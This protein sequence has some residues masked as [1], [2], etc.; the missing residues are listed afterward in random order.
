MT[1]GENR[2]GAGGP[3]QFVVGTWAS[4]GVD[5]N[6][7]G[8][9]S[10]YDARDAIPAAARY[11]RASGAPGD[12]RRALFAYNHAGWYVVDVAERAAAYRGAA[13]TDPNAAPASGERVADAGTPSLPTRPPGPIAVTRADYQARPLGSWQ[14]DNSRRRCRAGGERRARRRCR[15]DRQRHDW[16]R[17]AAHAL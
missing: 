1:S 4:Y 11:L 6:G 17:H 5:G 3:M 8:V 15:R 12:W 2:A 10:R 14:T 16:Q 13:H 7:D 9:V